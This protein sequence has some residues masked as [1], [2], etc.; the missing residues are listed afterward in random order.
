M[1]VTAPDHPIFPV[2]PAV[3][4]GCGGE[5]AALEYLAKRE[6]WLRNAEENPLRA[7][8]EPDT[9]RICDALLA[10]PWVPVNEAH[11]IRESLGFYAP[12]KWL[13]ILGGNR[14]GKTEYAAKT[15]M[16]L[17]LDGRGRQA[18]FFH[19]SESMSVSYHQ[20]LLYKYLPPHLRGAS[21]RE[22]EAYIAYSLQNGFSN[23]KFVLPNRGV[24]T[25]KNYSQKK[26]F[27]IEGG[28]VDLILNDELVPLD[29]VETQD[30]R[31]ATRAGR[32]IITFTPIE[33][34]TPTVGSFCEGA[35]EVLSSPAW[36][37]PKDGGE[38]DVDGATEREQFRI[39]AGRLNIRRPAGPAGRPFATVPR[40]LR[41][42]G[43]QRAVVYFH[44]SDNPFGNP[45]EVATRLLSKGPAEIKT[46]YYGMAEKSWS[47]RFQIQDTVHV[48]QPADIPA[49]GTNYFVTDP[50]SSRNW[51]MLWARCLKEKIYIYREWPSQCIPVAEHGVPGPWAVF[52]G[53]KL[54][55]KP[56][57]GQRAFGFG[58]KRYIEEIQRLEKHGTDKA[59]EIFQRIMDSR[60]ASAPH[61]EKDRPRT[62]LTDMED[63]GMFFEPASGADIE[64]GAQLI[65]DALAYDVRRPV[66]FMNCPKL[67]ISAECKNLLYAL[68]TW[69]GVD[70]NKGATKDFIDLVRYL[71][72][73]S[74]CDITGLPT[75][76]RG[77]GC[78]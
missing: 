44:S 56:G 43:G 65:V 41:C 57:P 74:P 47:A 66:N 18:W 68:K 40:V 9:W 36:L 2:N 32:G 14:A 69:T 67:Y 45:R 15:A 25:F 31:L 76:R 16:K 29:W 53:G 12:V 48:I 62:V 7:G 70:G 64:D 73:V 52:D 46:R 72:L 8:W 54:D 27:A 42:A 37:L 60:F 61:L 19:M 38:P 21:I 13:L 77:G 5:A 3:L 51:V 26:E 58:L 6:E 78:Y 33:G 39:R 20:P 35:D 34:Y 59:E 1:P 10:M 50:A 4:R 30:L 17:L 55:G 75:I 22:K 49:T 71:L 28:E 23:A 11:I 63:L 24:C